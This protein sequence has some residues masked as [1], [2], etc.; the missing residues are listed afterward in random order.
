MNYIQQ[1]HRLID[2]KPD[3]H[4][5]NVPF[6]KPSQKRFEANL[7]EIKVWRTNEFSQKKDGGAKDDNPRTD[8]IIC[9]V[10]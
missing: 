2:V 8:R 9:L 3:Y 10:I 1:Y 6:L 7:E 4:R 5:L